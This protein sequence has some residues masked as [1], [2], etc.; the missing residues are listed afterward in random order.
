MAGW[1][2]DNLTTLHPDLIASFLKGYADGDG[3]FCKG[4]VR[5]CTTDAKR[6]IKLQTTCLILGIRTYREFKDCEAYCKNL[7]VHLSCI[8]TFRELIGF[9]Q[10]QRRRRLAS[11]K[12]RK[13]RTERLDVVPASIILRE[14]F[15]RAREYGA[16]TR[17]F[18]PL[19]N[20]LIS[21]MLNGKA[22]SRSRFESVVNRL[23]EFG[24]DTT[25]LD[26]LANSQVVWQ[27]V[28][29]VTD[30]TDH[31]EEFVYDLTID[32]LHSF[33]ANG[34]LTHNCFIDEVDQAIS[35]G[36]NAGGSQQDQ[37]IFQRLLE[38]M[39]DTGH[40]G[41]AVVL[42]A[43]NRPDLM[44]AALRRPGRFD[45]KIPFLI[46]DE[47][48]RQAIFAVMC[49]RYGLQVERIPETCVAAT[50]GWTGAEIEAAVVK[51]VELVE[52]EA[53]E[54]AEAL[55]QAVQRI[56]PSTADIEFMT[57]LA[58]AEC[59]DLDLLPPKY[60]GLLDDRQTLQQRLEATRPAE[61][62]RGRREL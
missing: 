24:V 58:I 19:S 62:R 46:P 48:E 54:P 12:P 61:A 37:H 42:A 43:T 49:R 45:K 30:H 1:I 39:S 32:G 9:R 53:L 36:G 55:A 38:W 56:R 41:R 21:D 31:D 40:R 17:S 4:Y 51:T 14:T 20:S 47:E 22:A 23:K 50:D 35:R 60:R 6:S 25:A 15:Y 44:D 52:D 57:L 7:I 11:W 3:S 34:M 26:R 16:R 8:E 13:W 10:Q 59:N 5:F 29:R 28:T 2:L 27:K 18:A 33:I